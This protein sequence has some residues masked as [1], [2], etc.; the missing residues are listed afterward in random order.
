MVAEEE[1]PK[2]RSIRD[3]GAGRR[4]GGLPVDRHPKYKRLLQ[5]NAS[6]FSLVTR[7]WGSATSLEVRRRLHFIT[8]VFGEYVSSPGGVGYSTT[9][10]FFLPT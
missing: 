6:C 7:V 5:A 3:K 9:P 4:T 2:G 8:V 1:T 10:F